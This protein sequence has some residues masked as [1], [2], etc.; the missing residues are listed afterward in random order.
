[1]YALNKFEKKEIVETQKI[2]SFKT[3]PRKAVKN[4]LFYGSLYQ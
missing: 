1:M 2:D 3:D 4:N